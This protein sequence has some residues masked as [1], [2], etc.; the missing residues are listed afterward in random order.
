MQLLLSGFD[1]SLHFHLRKEEKKRTISKQLIRQLRLLPAC[2]AVT[3][4][5]QDQFDSLIKDFHWLL[6]TQTRLRARG[7]TIKHNV[8]T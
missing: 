5:L 3:E 7:T 8:N 6:L 1:N 2:Q 4:N